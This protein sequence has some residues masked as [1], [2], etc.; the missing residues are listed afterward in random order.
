MQ[1]ITLNTWGGSV[2]EPLKEFVRRQANNTD[3]FCFQEVFHNTLSK[4]TARGAEDRARFEVRANLLHEL[5][6]VLPDYR[7]VYSP[8]EIGKDFVGKVGYPLEFGLAMF[9]RNNLT[10]TSHADILIYDGGEMTNLGNMKRHMQLVEVSGAG[11]AFTIANAHGLWVR[12]GKLDSPAR[13]EQSRRIRQALNSVQHPYVLCGDFN[14]LPDTKSI[15]M[16]EEQAGNLVREYGVTSTRTPLYDATKP[17]FADY[18]FASP[19]IRV[20]NF[21][22]MPDVVSDH[23]PLVLMFDV[24]K[25]S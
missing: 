2:F 16:L 22:V 21:E 12:E 19:G 15:A 23:A 20:T 25:N 3:I 9:V 18:I 4:T 1:L 10:I 24:A 14:L 5:Q 17:Q 6:S 8:S 7:H 11:H 13:L